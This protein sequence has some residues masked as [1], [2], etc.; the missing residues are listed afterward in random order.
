MASTLG[1]VGLANRTPYASSK[2]ATVLRQSFGAVD[3]Y[4][5]VGAQCPAAGAR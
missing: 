1:V 4:E 5:R 3:I 2:G